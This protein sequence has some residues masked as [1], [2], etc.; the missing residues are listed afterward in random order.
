MSNL[1]GDTIG[2][3]HLIASLLA[4]L[5]GSLVLAMEKGTVNHVRVGY[6]YL[7]NMGIVIVTAFMVYRLFNSFGIFHYAALLSL[8]IITLGMIPVLT[9][10][11]T[12]KWKTRHFSFMY[13]SVI[14]LYAAFASEILTRIP[15]TPFLSMLIAAT[16][17]IC[18]L[19]GLFF[20][21][22]INNWEQVLEGRRKISK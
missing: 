3:I 20:R 14:G 21:R 22:N 2:L 15:E 4:L 12:G 9:K 17:I 16:S 7:I 10:K 18:I 8:L 13:W 11:P 6:A 1:V 5:F 19:G